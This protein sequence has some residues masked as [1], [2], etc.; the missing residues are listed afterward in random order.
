MAQFALDGSSCT[1]ILGQTRALTAVSAVLE[2]PRPE[3]YRKALC[4]S[5]ILASDIITYTALTGHSCHRP[6]EGS[7]RFTVDLSPM[8]SPAFEASYS[9]EDS[10]EVLR[11]LE[12][13]IRDI[14][15]V[16]LEALCVLPGR[17]VPHQPAMHKLWVAELLL[18]LAVLLTSIACLFRQADRRYAAVGWL[19]MYSGLDRCGGCSW[20]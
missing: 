1:V 13:G 17:K 16:D 20:T 15:A 14:R 7:L 3:R 8:A 19:I 9:G 6:N 11:L 10:A 2:A 18:L 12:R 5:F 4:T